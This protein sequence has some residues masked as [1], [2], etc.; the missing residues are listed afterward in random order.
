MWKSHSQEIIRNHFFACTWATSV[1]LAVAPDPQ[2]PRLQFS[3]SL[4]LGLTFCG[5]APRHPW[6][7][8]M[9]FSPQTQTSTAGNCKLDLYAGEART[10]GL[11]SCGLPSAV[12]RLPMTQL[13][14]ARQKARQWLMKFAPVLSHGN[15]H[16]AGLSLTEAKNTQLRRLVPI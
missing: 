12:R 5:P 4:A 7:L 6:V 11:S 3:V 2:L 10:A 8:S 14:G 13:K 15:K 9:R 1:S 16:A